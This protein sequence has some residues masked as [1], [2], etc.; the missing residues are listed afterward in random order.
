LHVQK[1]HWW[2]MLQEADRLAGVD[3]SIHFHVFQPSD[4]MRLLDWIDRNVRR[5]EV[6][7]GPS[8][9]PDSDE[10][11]VLLR[12]LPADAPAPPPPEGW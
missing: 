6:V 10:F 7:E 12:V 1:A 3:Y 8:M 9:S 11:H 2:T 4:M 5:L